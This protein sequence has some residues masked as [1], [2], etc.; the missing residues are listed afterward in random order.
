MG[1]PF[2]SLLMEPPPESAMPSNARAPEPLEPSADAVLAEALRMSARSIPGLTPRTLELRLGDASYREKW[3]ATVERSEHGGVL[4]REP[5]TVDDGEFKVRTHL[6][7]QV[8]HEAREAI[9]Q[10]S[11]RALVDPLTGQSKASASAVPTS[12]ADSSESNGQDGERSLSTQA[13]G[14]PIIVVPRAALSGSSTAIGQAVNA[15]ATSLQS[16]DEAFSAVDHAAGQS[17]EKLHDATKSLAFPEAVLVQL[18][19]AFSR[20]DSLDKVAQQISGTQAEIGRVMA[21]L[22]EA[23]TLRL[24]D[25]KWPALPDS[26]VVQGT[27]NALRRAHGDLLASVP[28]AQ[29]PVWRERS[30]VDYYVAIEAA[31]AITR[32]GRQGIDES[33]DPAFDIRA[34]AVAAA[35]T[36]SGLENK[37]RRLGADLVQM[38]HGA[39]HAFGAVSNPERVRHAAVSLRELATQVLHRLAPDEQ[40]RQWTK[41]PQDFD[42]GKPTRSARARFIARHAH[43]TLAEFLKQDLRSV[44]ALFGL[45]NS[46]THGDFPH[47]D[48]EILVL[49]VEGFIHLL[50]QVSDAQAVPQ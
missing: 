21:S 38:L 45:L 42:D 2:W 31:R 33:K 9:I 40:V 50:L 36:T 15:I 26:D 37:L 4:L 19:D 34:L 12:Q 14:T 1:V 30:T 18:A 6:P 5:E 44:G 23:A 32:V 49:R 43:P 20:H 8:L 47:N 46:A 13:G 29:A 16:L 11:R 22:A 27:Y 10:R 48:L 25:I 35:I 7:A 17:L 24:A 39:R 41:F 3:F 28:P